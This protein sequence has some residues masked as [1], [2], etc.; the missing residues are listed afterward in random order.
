MSTPSS[1]PAYGALADRPVASSRAARALIVAVLA[2][3]LVARLPRTL[4]T[5]EQAMPGD[6]AA[7]VGDPRLVDLAVQVGA[8]LGLALTL[9]SVLVFL[10]VAAQ[11]ERYLPSAVLGVGRVRLGAF[12]ATVA[13]CCLVSQVRGVLAPPDLEAGLAP[14]A[15]ALVTGLL[16]GL[17]YAW[18]SRGTATGRTALAGVLATTGLALAM[19]VT[20]MSA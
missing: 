8:L 18:R 15:L 19:S 20:T 17:G 5:V 14:V 2:V 16:V 13:A 11:L 4:A 7:S 1:V 9:V 6:V 10:L 12:T 3:F